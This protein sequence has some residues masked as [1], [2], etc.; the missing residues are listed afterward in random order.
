MSEFKVS[1]GQNKSEIQVW[2][3]TPLIWV[4]PSAGDLHKDIERR[5]ILS[6][7]HACIYLAA[8]LLESTNP[9]GL[10]N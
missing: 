3:Y 10:S 6:S 2:W 7:S 4:T 9:G 8:H 1:L 5:K